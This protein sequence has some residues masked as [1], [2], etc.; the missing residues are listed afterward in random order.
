M[1][2]SVMIRI[3]E[4]LAGK[5]RDYGL[6]ISRVSE[7]A[8]REMLRRLEQPVHSGQLE[9]CS[10][11]SCVAGGEGF[12]PPSQAPLERSKHNQLQVKERFFRHSR[13][14]RA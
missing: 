11:E 10:Y 4:G 9:K 6:N 1:N 14:A 13:M 8:L 3:D 12:E 5:A 7:N 2:K